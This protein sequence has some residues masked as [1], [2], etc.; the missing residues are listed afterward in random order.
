MENFM[1]FRGALRISLATGSAFVWCLL[2]VGAKAADS[3]PE[4]PVSS[5]LSLERLSRMSW[6]D[7]EQLYR[8]AS[9][10]AIPAGYARGRAIY[11]PGAFLTPTRSKMTQKLW[12]GKLFCPEDGTLVNEWCLGFHAIHA[13]VGYGS[14]W[15]DGKP[16]IVMDYRGT[17]RVWHDVRDEIREVA[18]GLYLGVMY[19][20]KA[21]QPRMKT[22]FALDFTSACP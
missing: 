13:R 1:L 5:A 18:P 20:C 14:S 15:L 21:S 11:C 6:C 17:S 22:Y 2:A 7:L 4:P 10:G 8:Q 3:A 12:H 19:R 16:S 9:P